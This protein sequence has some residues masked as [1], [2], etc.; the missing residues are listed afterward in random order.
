M[1]GVPNFSKQTIQTKKFSFNSLNGK[2]ASF[3][4]F[5]FSGFIIKFNYEF[6]HKLLYVVKAVA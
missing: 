6:I 3:E 1:Q 2:R 4:S 5:L